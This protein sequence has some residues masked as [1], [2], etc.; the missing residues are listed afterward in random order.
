MMHG[1]HLTVHAS[2]TTI[3]TPFPSRTLNCTTKSSLFFCSH[4]SAVR[5]KLPFL[6]PCPPS[7]TQGK[8][9]EAPN[10][11]LVRLKGKVNAATFTLLRILIPSRLSI[12]QSQVCFVYLYHC[13]LTFLMSGRRPSYRYLRKKYPSCAESLPGRISAVRWGGT[14]NGWRDPSITPGWAGRGDSPSGGAVRS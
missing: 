2:V 10:P 3:T 9:E 5:V 12:I 8:G 7:H 4:D 11:S 13:L 1:S 6:P 14:S